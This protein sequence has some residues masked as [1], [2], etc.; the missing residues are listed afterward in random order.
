MKKINIKKLIINIAVPVALGFVVG[1]IIKDY[2][3]I[4]KTLNKP[5]LS[6]P[7]I[8]FPIVWT[9]LY[10]VM[11]IS[12]YLAGNEDTK[13]IYYAQ[14]IVN[15]LWSIFFF[16]LRWYLFSFIWLLLLLYLI[17]VMMK[18]FYKYNELSSYLL[19][20]YL[21]WVTFAGYLNLSIF[22]LN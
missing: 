12:Y 14:L 8:L 13:K 3:P 17:I 1:M 2:I 21:I 16:V 19:I 15:L 20:P 10:I 4:Y 22:L 5:L 18:K 6:P 9:I 11:G 7:P